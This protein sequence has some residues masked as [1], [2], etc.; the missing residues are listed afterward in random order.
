MTEG[1][2]VTGPCS[3]EREPG[4]DQ[5]CRQ[6]VGGQ[7]ASLDDCVEPGFAGVSDASFEVAER[8]PLVQVGDMHSDIV[9]AAADCGDRPPL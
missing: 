6:P 9:K 1:S 4:V 3:A 5:S 7:D 2:E 8:T